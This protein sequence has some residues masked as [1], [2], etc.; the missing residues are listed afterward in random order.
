MVV[1]TVVFGWVGLRT[2]RARRITEDGIVLA[3]VSE[4]FA[5]RAG[6]PAGSGAGGW[7]AE[8]VAAGAGAVTR[9][10]AGSCYLCGGP[11]R[12]GERA[13]RVCQTCRA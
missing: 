6:G 4:D 13:S 3:G 1:L 9:S 11:L 8:R 7:G 12:A 5:E 10:E 2:I